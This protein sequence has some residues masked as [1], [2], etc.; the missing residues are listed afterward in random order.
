MDLS[1]NGSSRGLLSNSFISFAE[2]DKEF[3]L[4]LE[5]ALSKQ[6]LFIWI[7]RKDVPR[8]QAGA[9]EIEARIKLADV[10][11]PVISPDYWSSPT[12]RNEL[13]LAGKQN[14]KIV[15]VVRR[16]GED[17]TLLQS[18]HTIEP[19]YFRREDN[20]THSLRKLTSHLHPDL[21]LDAFISYSRKDQEF[22]N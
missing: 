19:I 4:D 21:H 1:A 3:V 20:F 13:V 18:L 14:K 17:K 6:N 11:I 5:H 9:R 22:V 2:Q 12:C 7:D 16:E 8:D 10:F 15:P